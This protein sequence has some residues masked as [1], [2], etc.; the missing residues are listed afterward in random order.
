MP[1]QSKPTQS[2]ELPL[3]K[4][5]RYPGLKFFKL[6]TELVFTTSRELGL[7]Y[8]IPTS[9]ISRIIG[10]LNEVNPCPSV[11]LKKGSVYPGF[12][13]SYMK[14]ISPEFLDGILH[15]IAKTS[16]LGRTHLEQIRPGVKPRNI[17]GASSCMGREKSKV[18]L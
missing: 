13:P 9:R 12:Q 10:D 8:K 1:R 18:Y 5:E 2:E 11:Y 14:A 16:A 3:V 4:I 15:Y 17:L 6:D 7:Y